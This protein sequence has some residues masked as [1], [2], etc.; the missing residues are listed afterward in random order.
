ML[1][2]QILFFFILEL[3]LSKVNY[4]EFKS[5]QV[6]EN[7]KE[8]DKSLNLPKI[9]FNSLKNIFDDNEKTDTKKFLSKKIE[10]EDSLENI[11]NVLKNDESD[12]NTQ[13]DNEK[14]KEDEDNKKNAKKNMIEN[15]VS[16]EESINS[17]ESLENKES[18]E[19]NENISDV[20]SDLF[21]EVTEIYEK[22]EEEITKNIYNSNIG[23]KEN[24][25]NSEN[26]D[27]QDKIMNQ[28]FSNQGYS[29]LENGIDTNNENISQGLSQEN[30]EVEDNNGN[31]EFINQED[32]NNEIIKVDET[33]KEKLINDEEVKSKKETLERKIQTLEG[34]ENPPLETEENISKNLINNI[35]KSKSNS[36]EEEIKRKEKLIKK[37]QEKVFDK[38]K[39]IE[40]LKEELYINEK[41]LQEEK[42][43]STDK[44]N[45]E[46]KFCGLNY[47]KPIRINKKTI[48]KK[49]S[50]SKNLIIH[51]KLQSDID[52]DLS[53][54]SNTGYFTNKSEK[55]KN[56]KNKNLFKNNSYYSIKD[57]KKLSKPPLSITF[58][59]TY[60]KKIGKSNF[61]CPLLLKGD[62]DLLNKKYERFPG[63][64]LS[65]KTGQIFISLSLTSKKPTTI[66]S[67]SLIKPKT[68]HIITL[69]ITDSKINLYING[70]LDSIKKLNNISLSPNNYDLFIGNHPV[71]LFVCQIEFVIEDFKIYDSE[72]DLGFVQSL[73]FGI[74]GAFIEPAYIILGCVDCGVVRALDSCEG[75]YHFCLNTE[76][77]SGVFFAASKMGWDLLSESKKFIFDSS[78]EHRKLK[79]TAVCCKNY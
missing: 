42:L 68:T 43:E 25:D 14:I 1:L 45:S 27:N 52:F 51:L 20:N 3:F 63:I 74:F 4:N 46:N 12:E 17:T 72:L 38:N 28:D 9:N 61:N 19:K 69:I 75:D 26:Y 64:Y 47:K 31:N 57:F 13:I 77:F 2:K 50:K 71:Y 60:N 40:N 35:E 7:K 56:Q 10:P 78:A 79:G 41:N 70:I 8:K 65:E 34:I 36:L 18:K 33:E 48:Y 76:F 6:R 49:P 15:E 32:D 30:E 23:Q 39:K 62:D 66:S 21:N 44:S 53:G 55:K 67:I 16:E 11:L 22:N 37:N 29:G 58:K 73:A 59:I 54:N 24:K 5:F